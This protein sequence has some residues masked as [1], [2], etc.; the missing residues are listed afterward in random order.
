MLF[1]AASFIVIETERMS[2]TANTFQL[3]G[4]PDLSKHRY[5]VTFTINLVQRFA[6]SKS[7][8]RSSQDDTIS[9][10][11]DTHT[12]RKKKKRG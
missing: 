9:V 8:Q 12:I 7:Q 3:S 5:E 6:P 2:L 1:R 4:S 11:F 10:S